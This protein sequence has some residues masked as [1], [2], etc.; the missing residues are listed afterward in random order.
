M[1]KHPSTKAN[2]LFQIATSSPVG[3]FVFQVVASDIDVGENARLSFSLTQSDNFFEI[4]E[5]LGTVYVSGNVM[6]SIKLPL[7]R[8]LNFVSY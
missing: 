4:D 1:F 5:E 6:L 2:L 7:F 3:Y 8:F